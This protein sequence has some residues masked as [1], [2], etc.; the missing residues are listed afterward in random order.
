ML[1]D[2]PNRFGHSLPTTPTT[3]TTGTSPIFADSQV[4]IMIP[5][6]AAELQ[7]V[8]LLSNDEIYDI[9]KD[10][11]MEGRNFMGP[12][13]PVP[14]RTPDQD[15]RAIS[16]FLED[17]WQLACWSCLNP[18]HATFT[19]RYLIPQY[20]LRVQV[21]SIPCW[22]QSHPPRMVQTKV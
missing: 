2:A 3:T 5:D 7:S 9:L 22:S 17:R 14:E 16:A 4:P 11:K 19:C 1:V 20:R 15:A 6:T 8:Y 10:C 13:E 18:K 12:T 21:L